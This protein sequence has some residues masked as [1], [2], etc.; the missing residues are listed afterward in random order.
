MLSEQSLIKSKIKV[1]ACLFLLFIL[2]LSLLFA[3]YNKDKIRFILKN[4]EYQENVIDIKNAEEFHDCYVDQ[5][6]LNITGNDAYI[7]Y[8]IK[9]SWVYDVSLDILVDYSNSYK[10]YYAYNQG[11]AENEVAQK[12][13][14]QEKYIIGNYVN[15]IRIDFEQTAPGDIY[16]LNRNGEIYLNNHEDYDFY[17]SDCLNIFIWLLLY[18]VIME[19]YLFFLIKRGK[20]YKTI[21]VVYVYDLLAGAIWMRAFSQNP[22]FITRILI[23]IMIG[24][25]A[26]FWGENTEIEN[27]L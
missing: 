22:E 9:Q 7:V 10:I 11:F 21:G 8:R 15:Q 1:Y 24:L 14:G 2:V 13:K 20:M 3:K 27:R 26:L 17:L 23:L 4:D 18:V 19:S 12:E 16:E 25:G 5:G 6:K